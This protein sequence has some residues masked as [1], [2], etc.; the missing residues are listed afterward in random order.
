MNIPGSRR[1]VGLFSGP[2]SS[3]RCA[4]SEQKH[5]RG[6]LI[7]SAQGILSD[8]GVCRG[9][10]KELAWLGA[11]LVSEVVLSCATRLGAQRWKQIFLKTAVLAE[12]QN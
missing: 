6:S 4:C 1:F 5:H 8:P 3:R 2:C 9:Y 10:G 12:R 7:Q 11:D